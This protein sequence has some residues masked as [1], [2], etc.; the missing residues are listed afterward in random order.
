MSRSDGD[1]AMAAALI[2]SIYDFWLT[3]GDKAESKNDRNCSMRISG[4]SCI[5]E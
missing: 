2:E 4:N 1:H 5:M 3:S